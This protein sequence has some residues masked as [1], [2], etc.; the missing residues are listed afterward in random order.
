MSNGQPTAWA[1]L[2]FAMVVVLITLGIMHGG[3]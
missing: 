2:F 1:V 3:G